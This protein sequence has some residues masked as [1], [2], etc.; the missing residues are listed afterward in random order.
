MINSIHIAAFTHTGLYRK[1]NEDSLFIPGHLITKT[2]MD[3]PVF[4][5]ITK[6][7]ALLAVADG[8]GGCVAGDVASGEVLR[9]LGKTTPPPDDEESLMACINGAA[10]H[11]VSLAL[12]DPALDGF[13]TTLSGVLVTAGY[14]FIFSCGDS[15]VYCSTPDQKRLTLM[16]KDHSVIQEMIDAGTLS[17]KEARNHPLGHVITSCLSGGRVTR[18]PDIRIQKAVPIS[19]SR[20][21]ICSDGVWDYGGEEVLKAARTGDLKEA[22][23]RMADICF[24]AGAP[25]NITFIIA[26][27]ES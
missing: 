8:L 15:R 2:A 4:N 22:S 23:K 24:D 17:E 20:I 14:L 13:G 5:T 27:M 18:R 16:T 10:D 3:N 19:G 6:F 9:Y 12:K 11:L 25:D 1:R 7:P 21:V 26:D